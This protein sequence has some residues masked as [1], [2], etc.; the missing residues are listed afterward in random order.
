MGNFRF[1]KKKMVG[2]YSVA[3]V[4]L[5]LEFEHGILIIV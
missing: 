2:V 5:L 4:R 1:A 3:N